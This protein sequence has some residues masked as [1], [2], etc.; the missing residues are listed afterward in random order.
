MAY[1][2]LIRYP[3]QN[4]ISSD[5]GILGNWLSRAVT[6]SHIPKSELLRTWHARLCAS[7][8]VRDFPGPETGA[9][10]EKYLTEIHKQSNRNGSV[11]AIGN[12]ANIQAALLV[13]VCR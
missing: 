2:E 1:P 6:K 9:Y 10:F 3:Y 4:R 11:K 12:S 7:G 8:L 5:N 13:L